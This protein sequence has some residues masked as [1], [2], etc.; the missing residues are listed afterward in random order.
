MHGAAYKTMPSVVNFLDS[1]GADIKI[2]SKV[3]R[4]GRTP[5][6]IAQGYR[7]GGNFKP[8]FETVKAIKN[9]MLAGGV[10]PPAAP[11]QALEKECH[12]NE[13]RAT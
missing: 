13:G 10:T 8:S 7:G 9:I 12:P 4:N 11:R 3:A 2:W 1:H 6:W 5:L